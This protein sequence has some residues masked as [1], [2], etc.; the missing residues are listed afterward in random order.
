MIKYFFLNAIRNMKKNS[1]FM[2]LNLL[3]LTIGIASFLLITLYVFHELS[4]DR[5]H[6]NYENIY[7]VKIT[8][9]MS[10]S[11]I[12]QAVTA[13]PM[14][15]ALPTDYPEVENTVRLYKSA[16]NSWL[17][18]YGDRRFY[19]DALL[20]ADSSF[21][22][23]FDF[24]MLRGDAEKALVNPKSVVLTENTAKKYFGNEDPLGK[25]LSL[26]ADSNLYTV[27]GVVRDIPSN[28]HFKF[29]ML[30]SFVTLPGSRSRNWI[31]HSLYTYVVLKNG[32]E[33]SSMEAKLQE[34][35]LKYVGPQ[36]KDFL[37]IT[38]EDFQKAGNQFRYEL[39]PLKDI[40]L[41]G[42]PQYP[43]Q[44]GGSLSNVLIF[45]IIALLILV[46]AIINYI[47]LATAKSA[48]RAKEVGIRKVSGSD[49]KS[50]VIQ[51]IGESLLVVT[52]ATVIASL[53]VVALAPL[54]SRITGIVISPGIIPGYMV[55]PGL[56]ILILFT[57][58]AAGSYPAFVLA[59]FNPVEVLK[60]TLSRGAG[61]GKL[62][63]ALV[64][65]QFAVSVAIII[66]AIVVYRQINFMTSS[67]MGIEKENLIIIKRSDILGN[68]IESFK[69]QVLR[70]PGVENAANATSIPGKLYSNNPFLLDND[71]TKA[72]HLMMQDQV[73]YGY[74]EAMGIKLSA[75]RF[76]SKDYG[77]DTTAIIINE[78]AVKS[79]A[80]DDPLGKFILQPSGPGK[81]VKRKIVGI[82]KDF[83]TESLHTRIAPVC[84]TFMSGNYPGYLCI[85][86][87][88][89][90]KNET[91]KAIEALWNDF[92]NREPFQYSFFDEEFNS[93]YDTE[94]RT[95]RIFIL[96]SFL[97]IFIACLGLIG[98]VTYT[99]AIRSREVGVRKTFGASIRSIVVL[100]S[101]EIVK[102][103]FISSLIA[104]P[105][106]YFWIKAWLGGF[107][108]K[109]NVSPL[110]YIFASLVTLII[111]WLSI[112][113]QAIK[114]ARRNP[115]ESLRQIHP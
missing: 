107:A 17:V 34:T 30:C 112:C 44:T 27:T 64:I 45:A 83:R 80:L 87:N 67:D 70:I 15:Q 41:K 33:K 32:T 72:T 105:V 55:F 13:A 100:L 22:N 88:G 113:Y 5:F 114:E 11:E 104:Y 16:A 26:E 95:G 39:E 25:R 103:I 46:I 4:Y 81:Y 73:S 29:D 35:V 109:V 90:N 10:G 14:A 99:T 57:G 74:P 60:G 71:A 59:S 78:T 76:F 49:K 97:A 19:E 52:M 6:K 68:Q 102:L 62:R 69:E 9:F 58:I 66:C 7:R 94:L 79:L 36:I 108:E 98:L 48:G 101:G 63:G 65:F 50:L 77:T 89:T 1:G 3:G 61:S 24:R 115:T 56:F 91:I 54:F 12:N 75:G 21:F 28:S 84:F 92:S 23:V 110:L 18:K 40:H 20:F 53:L 47:N 86:L 38:L 42:A 31:G 37:G 111:G 106:V 96:F 2:V 43:L 51:F 93:Q 8:G 82:M 85:R